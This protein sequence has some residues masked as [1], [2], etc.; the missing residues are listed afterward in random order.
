MKKVLVVGEI[1]V[2]LVLQGYHE[3]PAPGREVLVDDFSMVLGSASAICAMGLAR[4]GDPVAFLGKVG[5]D[6]WGRFCVDAMRERR[7][8]VS[9]VVVDRAVKTGVTVAITSPSDR[10]LVSFLGSIDALQ[11]S[12]VSGP[13]FHSFDHLHISSYFMQDRLRPSIRG[14]FAEARRL[15]LTTSLDPGFDPSQT[16]GRDLRDTLQ[17]VD[18][19]FPNEV[20]L[21]ALSGSEDPEEG[22]RRLQNGRTRIVAKLG[23]LGAMT[24]GADGVVKTSAFPVK[25]L[26]TTGAGDSFNA[27]FLHAWLRGEPALACLRLGA[28]CGA[29]STLGLG[30]TARQPSL[31]EAQAFLTSQG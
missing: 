17:E 23:S 27:G 6:T 12:D 25:A 2:D 29:L 21:R 18:L 28:A 9:R 8:D 11:G 10:A 31:D 19:F 22:V 5:D 3:F 20:E 16:W 1:N 7:I 24:M 13:A 4:L 15:G 26:D 30:G 14:L